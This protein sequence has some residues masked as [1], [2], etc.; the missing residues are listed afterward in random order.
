MEKE[1]I[2]Q[3]IREYLRDKVTIYNQ[4]LDVQLSKSLQYYNEHQEEYDALVTVDEYAS[5]NRDYELIPQDY[6][7]NVMGDR[8]IRRMAEALYHLNVPWKEQRPQ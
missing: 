4:Y 1:Q 8:N 5:P 2:E 3:K 7:V 6:L